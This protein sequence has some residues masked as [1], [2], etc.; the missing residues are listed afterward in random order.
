M[1]TLGNLPSLPELPQIHVELFAPHFLL[2]PV[3]PDRD[4]QDFVLAY[5][6]NQMMMG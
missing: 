4:A 6:N 3:A 1:S 5:A 2:L